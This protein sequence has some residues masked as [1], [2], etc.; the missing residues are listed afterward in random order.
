MAPCVRILFF[1][2]LRDV[3]RVNF[4]ANVAESRVD[5]GFSAYSMLLKLGMLSGW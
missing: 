5:T 4:R 2:G 1:L 3:V